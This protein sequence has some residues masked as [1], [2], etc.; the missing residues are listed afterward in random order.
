[1]AKLKETNENELNEAYLEG[2][3]D[4]YNRLL[5]CVDRVMDRREVQDSDTLQFIH[6]MIQAEIEYAETLKKTID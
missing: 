5:D 4:G 6:D 2:V 1:M 3:I